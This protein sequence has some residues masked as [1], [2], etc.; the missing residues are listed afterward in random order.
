MAKRDCFDQWKPVVAMVGVSFASAIVNISLK[1]AL[2]QGMSHLLFITYRQ[3]ISA[4]FLIPIVCFWER[5][6]WKHLTCGILCSLFF[7]GLLGAT[8]TQYFFLVGLRYTSP[9]YTCAFINVVPVITFMLALPLRQEK[10]NLKISSGRAKVLGTIV[11]VGGALVLI[12]YKGMPVINA[13][14]SSPAMLQKAKHDTENWVIGSIFLALGGIVWA[15][16]FLIQSWI[17]KFYPYQYCSTALLCFFSAIQSAILC[18]AVERPNSWTLKGPLQIFTI[19]Y[20]GIV[21]SGLG[22]VSM[23]WC[24]KQRGP[25][26]TAAFSPF[27]QIFVAIFGVSLLHE[28][29]NLGSI[30]GSILVIIGM[31]ILLWGKS[32]EA[33]T[34]HKNASEKVG[35]CN[36][37]LPVTTPTAAGSITSG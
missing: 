12:L 6:C 29:I 17:G 10:V 11:C 15:S 31:Y 13:P 26:F 16:W 14:K 24:V 25:V 37:T 30:L 36:H 20:A 19:I 28:Q 1:K 34:D 3:S 22:Y 33:D 7:S 2:N 32:K 8:L 18:V 9:T 4:I 27:L 21:G 23:S 5:K 35:D